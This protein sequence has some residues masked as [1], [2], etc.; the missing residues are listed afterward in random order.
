MCSAARA[1]H[2]TICLLH[3]TSPGLMRPQPMIASTLDSLYCGVKVLATMVEKAQAPQNSMGAKE[4]PAA[5]WQLISQALAAGA[6]TLSTTAAAAA[7]HPVSLCHISSSSILAFACNRSA[8]SCIPR[9]CPSCVQALSKLCMRQ[10]KLRPMQ[11]CRERYELLL[12][13]LRGSRG[14]AGAQ[15]AGQFPGRIPLV[16]PA[17][18][19][20]AG[21]ALSQAIAPAASAARNQSHAAPSAGLQLA[22][23]VP[24]VAETVLASSQPSHQ[25]STGALQGAAVLPAVGS[26]ASA[27]GLAASHITVPAYLSAAVGGGTAVV[28]QH[29]SEGM[30]PGSAPLQSNGVPVQSSVR[31]PGGSGG[32]LKQ[33]LHMQGKPDQAWDLCSEL[34]AMREHLA[35]LA[36]SSVV[37]SVEVR[38]S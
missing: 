6:A 23:A 15:L 29:L 35:W 32:S 27:P 37:C 17:S 1:P 34:E 19:S 5:L 16:A 10:V 2:A 4:I 7:N 22:T 38:H 24:H 21:T 33:E 9:P 20:L 28:Q 18:A 26:Q 36:S 3:G 30:Q 31:A 8:A 14:Q 11:Q 25:A 12:A 13:A